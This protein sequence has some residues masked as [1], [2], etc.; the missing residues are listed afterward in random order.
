MNVLMQFWILTIFPL[1]LVLDRI[2][3]FVDPFS[4]KGVRNETVFKPSFDI[5]LSTF[6]VPGIVF[7]IVQTQ[8]STFSF[9]YYNVTKSY[10]AYQLLFGCTL[11][12][13]YLVLP[14]L[15]NMTSKC[16]DKKISIYFISYEVYANNCHSAT[17]TFVI[18]R[19]PVT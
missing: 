9:S 5:C 11:M 13:C 17:F 6:A 4:E 15:I 16:I 12:S 1:S 19:L 7:V 3:E 8:D 18:S 14:I 10:K 2:K